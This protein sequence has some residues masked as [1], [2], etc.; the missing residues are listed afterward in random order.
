M[1]FLKLKV[2]KIFQWEEIEKMRIPAEY[3][4]TEQFCSETIAD[5]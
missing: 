3:N 2:G 1:F 5:N 4:K